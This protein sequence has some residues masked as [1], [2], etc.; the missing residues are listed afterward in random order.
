MAAGIAEQHAWEDFPTQHF[1]RRNA[2]WAFCI[3]VRLAMIEVSITNINQESRS[4]QVI[5]AGEAMAVEVAVAWFKDRVLENGHWLV[6]LPNGRIRC[7]YCQKVKTLGQARYWSQAVCRG[8]GAIQ[9]QF[10]GTFS[11]C[12]RHREHLSNSQIAPR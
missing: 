12:G 11:D 5:V 1:A 6:Q 7:E 9:T 3:L 8:E 4:W 10:E 2:Q